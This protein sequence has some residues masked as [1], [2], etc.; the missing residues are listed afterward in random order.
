MMKIHEPREDP[1]YT[2]LPA[3]TDAAEFAMF[4]SIKALWDSKRSAG[5]LPAWKD[6]DLRDFAGW[7]GWL[8]VADIVS[9]S[10]FEAIYRLWGTKWTDLCHVDYTGKRYSEQFRPHQ[11]GPSST[12]ASLSGQL[13]FWEDMSRTTNIAMGHGVMTWLDP[14]HPLFNKDFRDLN[15]PLSDEGSLPDKYLTVLWVGDAH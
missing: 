6:F 2:I 5:H 3:D 7:Y 9:V 8:A 4:A 14:G 11:S 15:L 13:L 10:P 12:S 1:T